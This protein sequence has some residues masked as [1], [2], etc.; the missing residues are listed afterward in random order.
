MFFPL[1][2]AKKVEEMKH[3]SFKQYCNLEK[4]PDMLDS[5]FLSNKCHNLDQ[6]FYHLLVNRR[7]DDHFY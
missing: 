2:E 3:S 4:V 7:S 1:A 5:S 6:G